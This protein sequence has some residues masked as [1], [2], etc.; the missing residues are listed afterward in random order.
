MTNKTLGRER[1]SQLL[2]IVV[3]LIAAPVVI[4]VG[5][6]CA[7][8]IRLDSSGPALFRQER[9][10]K[11]GVPFTVF[12]F[13]TMVNES[14]PIVP[15]ASRITRVGKILRR[16][17]LDELPQL[18]NV[19]NGTMS[20]VGPRPTLQ[21]QVDRYS[22]FQR[23]RLEV[24]PGLTGLAQVNGR[25][26]LSWERRIELDVEYVERQSLLLDLQIITR[27]IKTV[28][29]GEGIDGHD[30]SDPLVAADTAASPDVANAGGSS[31]PT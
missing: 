17:S 5:L 1:A 19:A 6:M 4:P 15:D 25:N 24:R 8:A 16:F 20:I 18:I 31:E 14:N 26:A 12:K 3:L 9:V 28:L 30:A 10:G 2:G 22:D 7:L 29:S 23:R 21:Y 27:T 11:G 13:R